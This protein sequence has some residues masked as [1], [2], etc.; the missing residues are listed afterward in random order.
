MLPISVGECEGFKKL[1][2]HLKPEY[3][4]PLRDVTQHIKKHFEWKKDELK[5]KLGRADKLALANN[6]ITYI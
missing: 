6:L 2:R 3:I 5:A 1:V 4:M